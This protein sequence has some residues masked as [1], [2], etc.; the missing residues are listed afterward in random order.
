MARIKPAAPSWS[1]RVPKYKIAQLY[2]D[3]ASGMQDEKLLN[4]VAFTLL[5]RCKSMLVVEA[6]RNGQATCPV[7]EAIIE[8]EGNKESLLECRNCSWTGSWNNY[9][10]SMDGLHL[11]APGLFPFIREYVHRLPLTKTPEQKMFWID[12]I[13]HRCHWEGTALPGQPGAVCLIQ[14]RASDVNNFLTNLSA[15][16]IKDEQ[17]GEF[18]NYWSAEKQKQIRRWRQASERRRGNRRNSQ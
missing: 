9:R 15:G 8:H 4:D 16:K 3:D 11:I 10:A 17:A 12:W 1:G 18:E 7:C 2:Q 5:A 14:G 6:A 13:I